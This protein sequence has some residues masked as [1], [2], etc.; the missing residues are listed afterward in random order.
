MLKMNTTAYRRKHCPGVEAQEWK[1]W[2]IWGFLLP[3]AVWY[4]ENNFKR[5]IK[6]KIRKKTPARSPPNVP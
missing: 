4:W 6:K 2:E 1:G 5:V 3:L